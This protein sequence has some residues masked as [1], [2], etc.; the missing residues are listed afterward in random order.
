MAALG[1]LVS[2]AMGQEKNFQ[3]IY[4]D[5]LHI[6]VFGPRKFVVMWMMVAA[7]EALGTPFQYAKFVGGIEVSFVGF[8]LDYGKCQMGVT[9]KRGQWL[10]SFVKEMEEARFTVHMHETLWGVPGS[11]GFLG[12]RFDLVEGSLGTAVQLGSG[13]GQ[14]DGSDSAT[15]GGTGA[16]ISL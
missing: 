15:D 16:Y 2:N 12:L 3:L 14:R 6:V 7:Y 10:V 11:A 9:E 8:Q 1:R 5:D 13:T 4:V